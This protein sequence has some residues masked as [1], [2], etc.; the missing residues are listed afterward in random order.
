MGEEFKFDF[1]FGGADSG[2]ILNQTK[3]ELLGRKGLMGGGEKGAADEEVRKTEE[4]FASLQ[5][6]KIEFTRAHPT[7]F[8]LNLDYFKQNNLK[9][10]ANFEALSGQ[11]KF[12]W[13][14]VPVFLAPGERPFYKMQMWMEFGDGVSEGKEIPKV[15]SAFPETRFAEIATVK[16][17]LDF[18]LG[19]DL[20]F[21]VAA[22]IDEV[23]LP[24]GIP[25]VEAS[26]GGKLTVDARAASSAGIVA[27][28]FSYTFKRGR[29]DCRFAGEQ[30][31]W[32][33]TD[34]QYLEEDRPVFIVILRTP[35][36]ATRVQ[37][38]A[39]AQA[40]RKAPLPQFIVRLLDKISPKSAEWLKKGSPVALPLYSPLIDLV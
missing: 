30:V 40:H 24:A 1:D 25:I 10:P 4:F 3:Q 29:V 5:T 27:G 34:Q 32:T 8:P 37:L 20:T 6:G 12:Y 2:E 28:P 23:A 39:R 11:S 17:K 16:G 7:V 9:P 21:K 38:N 18:G 31:L 36:D 14:E 33:I 13:V 26:A 19:E 15:H 22:G 35:K